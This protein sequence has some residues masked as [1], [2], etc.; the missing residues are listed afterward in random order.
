MVVKPSGIGKGDHNSLRDVQ[1][2]MV[3]KLATMSKYLDILFERCA[4]LN[5]SKTT[6]QECYQL[7]QFERC[8]I[9]NG[10]KTSCMAGG[11]DCKFERCAILNGS[12][13]LRNS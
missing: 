12:K 9:L 3:V 5:G 1:F 11:Q 7:K 2:S 6:A 10:S 8:A 4:I 13:T